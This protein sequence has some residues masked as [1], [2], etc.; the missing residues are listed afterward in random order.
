MNVLEYNEI[1]MKLKLG[2]ERFY[3]GT[4]KHPHQTVNRRLEVAKAQK[5]IA[6]IV[7][8]SDSR[9]IPEIIFDQGLG[10]LFVICTA[11]N[12]VDDLVIGSIEYAVSY[13]KTK[14]III[15]GHT[16][17]GAVDATIKGVD[18]VGHLNVIIDYINPAVTKAQNQTGDLLTNAIRTNINYV[19]RQLETTKPVLDNLV[20]TGELKIIGGLYD[21]TSGK[22][23]FFQ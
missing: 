21:L 7:T 9:V 8:C 5:P 16:N 4:P 10:D 12:L 1:L 14:L 18:P 13:L 20:N 11:G 2:N 6:V 22:V 15:L 19:I 3:S 23:E 17:C